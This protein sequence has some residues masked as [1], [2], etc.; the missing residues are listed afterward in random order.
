M[1]AMTSGVPGYPSTFWFYRYTLLSDLFYTLLFAV[2]MS[3]PFKGSGEG[4]P[5]GVRELA[6][7]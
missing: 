4:R 3:V 5:E 6:R 7:S 1:Q 2:G